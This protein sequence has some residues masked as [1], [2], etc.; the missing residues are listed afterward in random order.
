MVPSRVCF[1][2]PMCSARPPQPR[3][4][5]RWPV[6]LGKVSLHLLLV[7]GYRH[8]AQGTGFMPLPRGH[9]SDPQPG[10][11]QGPSHS[12]PP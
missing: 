4:R 12:S 1:N 8:G 5:L 2:V 10:A 7:Q 3:A 9:P 11:E 6:R